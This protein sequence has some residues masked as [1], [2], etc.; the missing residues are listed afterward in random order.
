MGDYCQIQGFGKT[1]RLA[2]LVQE[3]EENKMLCV[4][5]TK[6]GT[7]KV[8]AEKVTEDRTGKVKAEKV[9]EDGTGK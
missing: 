8:K 5:E 7:G 6:D 2:V 1:N 9:T 3:Q 4:A